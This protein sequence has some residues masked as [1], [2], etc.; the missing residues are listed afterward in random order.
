M[1]QRSVRADELRTSRRWRIPRARLLL[2]VIHGFYTL[3][4]IP[5][6]LDIISSSTPSQA[7][8]LLLLAVV[9]ASTLTAAIWLGPG[10]GSFSLVFL[11]FP[12]LSLLGFGPLQLIKPGF[13]LSPQIIDGYYGTMVFGLAYFLFVWIFLLLISGQ[14][15]RNF[16]RPLLRRLRQGFPI[17]TVGTAAFSLLALT[18]AYIYQPDLPGARYR[19]LNQNLLP[20]NAWNY[21]ALTAYFFV[22]V[23]RRGWMR[24]TTLIAIPLWFLLHFS[25]V[26][27]LGLLFLYLLGSFRRETLQRIRAR[28]SF[29][30]SWRVGLAIVAVLA[31]SYLGLV[32]NGGL[33]W[34][35]QALTAA[36]VRL[37]NYP[38][39][40]D[41]VYGYA[42]TIEYTR[43][44]GTV[45]SLIELPLRLLPSQLVDL[46]PM[47]DKLVSATIHTNN[48]MLLPAEFYLNGRLSGLLVAPFV[49]YLL[50]FGSLR[51][52][53]RSALW[54]TLAYFLLVVATARIFWYG[55][56][57]FLKPLVLITPLLLLVHLFLVLFDRGL[58]HTHRPPTVES[59]SARPPIR[60]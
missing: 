13:G 50:L 1:I 15:A 56:I 25:R 39:V 60:P 31:L 3:A 14:R 4:A 48:G 49:T 43:I 55:L 27:V 42:A 20:G 23:G 38:T 29:R 45:P 30:F 53:R 12:L 24:T 8:S 54:S 32:R 40:Q 26:E 17:S 46:P 59:A 10:F 9:T 28:L 19:D 16:D 7:G 41:L 33:W 11:Y 37:V 47:P 34:D 22:V 58:R 2:L 6:L 21:L 5:P 18:A 35:P 44:V 51:L 57:F 36:T 52:L